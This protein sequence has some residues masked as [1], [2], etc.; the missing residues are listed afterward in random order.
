MNKIIPI[1]MDPNE[2]LLGADLMEHRIRHSQIGLSRAISA[3]APIKIN[4]NEVAGIQPI[5]LN[6]GHEKSLEQLRAA[7]DKLQQW[8]TYLNQM[9]P[10]VPKTL[11]PGDDEQHIFKKNTKSPIKGK[12]GLTNTFSRRL[13]TVHINNTNNQ[14]QTNVVQGYYKPNN[15]ELPIISNNKFDGGDKDKDSNFAWLD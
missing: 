5:G 3:L 11:Q 4:L 14:T 6:P 7:D 13:K 15:N 9:G 2:E 10:H 8:Q 12:S 1:R